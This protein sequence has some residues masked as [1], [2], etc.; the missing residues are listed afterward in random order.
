MYF[1]IEWFQ[2]EEGAYAIYKYGARELPLIISFIASISTAALPVIVK[3]QE[4][5]L[6]LL[7]SKTIRLAHFLFPISI[8]LVFIS[9]YLF[10]LAYDEAYLEAAVIFNI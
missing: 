1:L 7:K 5:G 6:A 8:I 3:N 10:E 4:E 2:K 9:K